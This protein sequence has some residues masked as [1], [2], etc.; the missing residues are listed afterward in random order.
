[1][2]IDA[3]D[4]RESAAEKDL[5]T[6]WE[7]D[8][9]QWTG[10]ILAIRDTLVKLQPLDDEG[11]TPAFIRYEG[12]RR[13]RLGRHAPAKQT[14]APLAVT[15]EIAPPPLPVASEVAPPPS[16]VS[17][18][19]VQVPSGQAQLD[20]L[21][22]RFNLHMEQPLVADIQPDFTLDP[23]DSLPFAH[24]RYIENAV[25][26]AKNIYESACKLKEM[27]R[28]GNAVD[29]LNKSLAQ[30]P[31][32][33]VLHALKGAFL[34]YLDNKA[35]ALS[36]LE[37]AAHLSN[38][39]RRWLVLG[40]VTMDTPV[41]S[42][43]LRNYFAA[44]SSTI[45][46]AHWYAFIK[47]SCECSAFSGLHQT[48]MKIANTTK[49]E[50]CLKLMG[51]SLL[52]LLTRL[53]AEDA[54]RDAVNEVENGDGL[55]GTVQA[56]SQTVQTRLIEHN[57][58]EIM[59]TAAKKIEAKR[60]AL[61]VPQGASKPAPPYDN[62]LTGTVVSFRRPSSPPCDFWEGNIKE[63]RHDK[64]IYFRYDEAHIPDAEVH[65]ALLR[66]NF[67]QPI[68][69]KTFSNVRGEKQ[70]HHL[71]FDPPH[72]PY[73]SPRP[74]IPNRVRSKTETAPENTRFS[75]I[76]GARHLL[77]S[78]SRA[79]EQGSREHAVKLLSQG[80][81]LYP[82][83]K[84]ILLYLAQQLSALGRADEAADAYKELIQ[85][86][87]KRNRPGALK[88]AETQY[89]LSSLKAG[90]KDVAELILDELVKKY[91]GDEYFK[92]LQERAATWDS[93][94]GVDKEFLEV[95]GQF[96]DMEMD[97]SL[98]L[99]RELESAKFY[100]QNISQKGDKPSPE[101]ANR[102]MTLAINSQEN[103]TD[104]ERYRLFLE[105]AKAY[106]LLLPGSYSKDDYHQALSR[107]AM[108]KG[109]ALVDRMLLLAISSESV[110]KDSKTLTQLRDS[111]TSYY[112]E[113]LSWLAPKNVK[114][115][116]A[117]ILNYFFKS[118][119]IGFFARYPQEYSEKMLSAEFSKVFA[120]TLKSENNA[121]FTL[122]C[123]AV[124]NWGSY[125]LIWN[126]L[127]QIPQGPGAI[128]RM[129]ATPSFKSKVGAYFST[130]VGQN[131]ASDL[132]PRD[133]LRTAFDHRRREREAMHAFC[134]SLIKSRNLESAEYFRELRDKLGK[135]PRYNG[136]LFAS[137][138]EMFDRLEKMVEEMA[139]YK[140]ASYEERGDML[141]RTRLKLSNNDLK[142]PGL[143]KLI[144]Q[145]PTYWQRVGCE[146]VI[147]QCLKTIGSIEAKRMADRLPKLDFYL[148]PPCFTQQDD[149]TLQTSLRIKNE[150]AASANRV[151]LELAVSAPSPPDQGPI[152][153]QHLSLERIERNSDSTSVLITL[154]KNCFDE[155]DEEA[156]LR[157]RAKYLEGEKE[158]KSFTLEKDKGSVFT[159]EDIP[160]HPHKVAEDDL[161]KGRGQLLA[162]L[163]D[164]LGK[165]GR[166]HSH[167]L[168]GVTRSGKTSI[169]RSF[170]ATETGTP[171][172]GDDS[173]RTIA[174]F[175][176]PFNTACQENSSEALWTYLLITCMEKAVQHLPE[177][178]RA[179]L[180]KTLPESKTAQ[181]QDWA[182]IINKL[183]DEGWY[184]VFLID[185]FSYLR[186]M[187]DKK[188]I[189]A[190]FLSSMRDF[191]LNGQAT[192]IVAGTYDIKELIQDGRYGITGQF[193]NF[194]NHFITSIEPEPARDII[195]VFEPKLS[196]TESAIHYILEQSDCRPYII[197][198]ICHYCGMY[199]VH[200][201]RSILGR[202][203]VGRVVCAL[204]DKNAPLEQIPALPMTH[205]QDNLIFSRARES[206]GIQNWGAIFSALTTFISHQGFPTY[207]H[208][209]DAWKE[210]G[211]QPDLLAD[212]LRELIERE[213]IVETKDEG[214]TRYSIKVGLFRHWW[215]HEHENVDMEFDA[216]K[217][218]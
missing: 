121:F 13:F 209:R 166:S 77:N 151:E 168:Y 200:Q 107:Y 207:G 181:S 175:D 46:P 118:L 37:M 140:N 128:T 2:P 21:L 83:D 201:R 214:D 216:L 203:E 86:E 67:T 119:L 174:C 49:D 97:I 193:A 104:A 74:D 139:S 208:L 184:P 157:I 185:E 115:L 7:D 134:R 92:T 122:A 145:A 211:L 204:T 26:T 1:M 65:E 136:A 41:K 110:K 198:T 125:P 160:W 108:Q 172:P 39:A 60:A 144:D 12:I 102:L 34:L 126:A 9:T 54:A 182:A 164:G 52:F 3:Q 84:D 167:V 36:S 44:S 10:T 89:V 138:I 158:P 189:D 94:T 133:I 4:F 188:L 22:E 177:E 27:S 85:L 194:K 42:L 215:M 50:K 64:L 59:L 78:A 87:K 71:R 150:G 96:D 212:G 66:Q 149:G 16:S 114:Y 43:A 159:F 142:E 40:L 15:S 47:A 155:T 162:E 146:A 76:G 99:K 80:R 161:F 206:D 20:L 154:P 35:D 63:Y 88:N 112:I 101:D 141:V 81:S 202:P 130:V 148:D 30:Y 93:T 75:G 100:D 165:H 61:P 180:R 123:D 58:P 70:A 19:L 143:L 17:V 23:D 105:A 213:V 137:D 127:G 109:K 153:Q 5:I 18:P 176:W 33:T 51:Q 197:Q 29:Q 62:W 129:M 48:I 170:M 28:L 116:G 169:L 171:L 111:A 90:R 173:N 196:F 217:A 72:S 45:E 73:G 53:G 79:V 38:T 131:I 95:W 147:I 205:F 132:L 135:F 195:N 57:D 210:E 8:G 25:S 31:G 24:K 120:E 91:P 190:S 199:A 218:M 113:A 156:V 14:P 32:Q 98:F 103:S 178:R 183:Q 117:S 69:F 6:I 191:A 68:Y 186:T 124:L 179:G 192:F 82:D 106:S 152:F 163:K 11:D 187:F 56:L 55:Q